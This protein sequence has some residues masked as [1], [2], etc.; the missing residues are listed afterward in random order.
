METFQVDAEKKITITIIV[1]LFAEFGRATVNTMLEKYRKQEEFCQSQRMCILLRLSKG[2]TAVWRRDRVVQCTGSVAAC[3]N[4][5]GPIVTTSQK[6]SEGSPSL[7]GWLTKKEDVRVVLPPCWDDKKKKDAL[8]VLVS[9]VD[10]PPL[11]Q[12]HQL[13]CLTHTRTRV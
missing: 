6:Q 11:K 8:V 3:S 9:S 12:G 7:L 5:C 10:R 1:F 2:T 13:S 4:D